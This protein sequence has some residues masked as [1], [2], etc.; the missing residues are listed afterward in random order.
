MSTSQREPISHVTTRP[1]QPHRLPTISAA[2][3]SLPVFDER[4]RAGRVR[5][6]VWQV[7]VAW[8]LVWASLQALGGMYSW[9][10]FVTGGTLLTHPAWASGG[11]HVFAAHPE[12]QMGPVALLG[13]GVIVLV[14]GSWSTVLGAL[15]M[16][17]LGL[18]NLRILERTGA[19]LQRR[20]I[21]PR[22]TLVAGMV[23]VPIWSVLAVHFGHLD[24]VLAMT[25]A[26][27]AIAAVVRCRMWLAPVLLAMAVD[28]KP[29]AAAFGV[30]LLLSHTDRARRVGLFVALT[31]AIWLPFLL[32]DPRTLRLS[33][34]TIINAP[35]SALRAIGIHSATTPSWDRPAQLALGAAL[36][37]WCLRSGK[38]AAVPLA[39]LATRMLLDPGTYP[40]Y[41]AGL[42]LAALFVDLIHRRRAL[43]WWSIAVAGWFVVSTTLVGLHHLQA[44]GDVRAAFLLA[45]ICRLCIGRSPRQTTPGAPEGAGQQS[46]AGAVPVYSPL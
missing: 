42:L 30:I 23:L 40:Y 46:H 13:A 6:M 24:D 12:L 32:A 35:D 41:T 8:A 10:Y 7:L 19:Q 27:A 25:F 43:P 29:W 37:W 28:A 31:V 3:Q 2:E 22:I 1:D 45:V 20:P 16:M 34:F 39:V 17:A 14:G 44:A 4:G 18:V 36:A 9:H 38:W 33:S 5:R 26:T 11:L 15:V 21:S